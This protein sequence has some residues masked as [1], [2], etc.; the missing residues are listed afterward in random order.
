MKEPHVEGVAT[1]HGPEPCDGAR[2]DVGE[3]LAGVRAGW[4][5]SR[6]NLTILQGADALRAGGRQHSGH[7]QREMFGDPARSETPR[8][9]G[10]FLHGNREIPQ[11]APENGTGVRAVNPQGARRR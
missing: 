1:H 9:H 10:T 8:T 2:E 11:L 7:R 3:A 5:L 6:E 4:V